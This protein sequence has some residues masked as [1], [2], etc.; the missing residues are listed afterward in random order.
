MKTA[1]VLQESKLNVLHSPTHSKRNTTQR[2]ATQRSTMTNIAETSRGRLGLSA[3]ASAVLVA[4]LG[5]A[6][7]LLN[8]AL[9]VKPSVTSSS[10]ASSAR[11][12]P[13]SFHPELYHGEGRTHHFFEGWY[14]KLV[15]TRINCRSDKES[16]IDPDGDT[17]T[18]NHN[19]N[20]NNDHSLSM[21]VVPG[22]FY[23]SGNNAT[24]KNESHAFIFVTINGEKQ[25]YYRFDI[26][27]EFQYRRHQQYIS[28]N[29]EEEDYYVQ[30]GNNKF[31]KHGMSLDLVP[32]R[33]QNPTNDANNDDDYDDDDASI[34]LKGS[35]EY[36]DIMP[37]PIPSFW[38]LGAMGPVGYF[39][40]PF[41]ECY[42][43]VLSFDHGLKG[44]LAISKPKQYQNQ[45]QNHDD[46]NEKEGRTAHTID[47]NTFH[48]EEFFNSECNDESDD[49]FVSSRGYVEKDRGQ[50]FPS[51][52]IWMQTNAFRNNAGT[53]LFFSVARIPILTN[54]R[55]FL[56]RS[57]TE[58]EF[59]GFTAAVLL[60]GVEGGAAATNDDPTGDGNQ[61]ENDDASSSSP[62]SNMNNN[63][64]KMLIPFA[65]W[66]GAYFEDLIVEDDRVV[67]TLNSGG[68]GGGFWD[69]SPRSS[70]SKDD[71][72][73]LAIIIR[74]VRFVKAWIGSWFLEYDSRKLRY[75]LELVAD[76]RV[77]HVLLYAPKTTITSAA[78]NGNN[79]QNN[80]N[81]IYYKSSITSAATTTSK[82]E[83]FVNEALNAKITVRLFEYYRSDDGTEYERLLLD[84]V[85]E[86]AGLEVHQNVQY[87]VDNLCGKAKAN[88]FMCL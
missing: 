24:G 21:A 45:N 4:F 20:H 59:P 31:S 6:F 8:A 88:V 57:W 17:H 73:G 79:G 2:N 76:R 16:S 72:A 5:I 58:L 75:K 38:N 7:S 18:H 33:R 56:P 42:H 26:D 63:I 34:N 11:A 86:H 70:S 12:L 43:D 9:H 22:V 23:D 28:S 37:W 87:L 84:D 32:R 83:P 51:L 68:I 39:L 46:G 48:L 40:S 85:G 19:H 30:I 15:R 27:T 44:T 49:T 41:L 78:S 65:T 54:L 81:N 71:V 13:F 53:S 67:A 29:G 69:R 61:I 60:D 66:T 14:H 74:V 64:T 55:K 36:E 77:P 35:I 82:M 80:N 1:W 50:S 3:T 47:T 25:H 52:W 10:S 62:S